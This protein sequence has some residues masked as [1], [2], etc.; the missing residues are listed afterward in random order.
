MRRPSLD[1]RGYAFSMPS[2]CKSTV[3]AGKADVVVTAVAGSPAGG[4]AQATKRT[5]AVEETRTPPELRSRRPD[6]SRR[7]ERTAAGEC[8]L[9]RGP[10]VDPIDEAAHLR[11][12]GE[13]ARAREQALD[14]VAH[15][16]VGSG[17]RIAR[18]PLRALERLL[19]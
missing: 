18:E 7:R 17:E 3:C 13:R 2:S 10:L 16:H 19:E 15:L 4:L 8:P 1:G 6:R 5:R 14:G 11:P 12:H 9:E